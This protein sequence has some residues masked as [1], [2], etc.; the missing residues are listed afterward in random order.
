MPAFGRRSDPEGGSYWRE[1]HRWWV[2][3]NHLR[4]LLGTVAAV[5]LIL[6]V[7]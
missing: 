7:R 3:W 5:P 4:A 6:A 1:Y 2:A